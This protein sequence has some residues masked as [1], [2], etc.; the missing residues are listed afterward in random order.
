M[1][2]ARTIAIGI[3]LNFAN[4]ASEK[5]INNFFV[6]KPPRPTAKKLIR[7]QQPAVDLYSLVVGRTI[8][9]AARTIAIGIRNCSNCMWWFFYM[10]TEK[11]II[12]QKAAFQQL[13]G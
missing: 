9:S 3:R 7:N 10:P 1:N 2:A 6:F 13:A 8:I 4:C 11:K 12:S 5:N